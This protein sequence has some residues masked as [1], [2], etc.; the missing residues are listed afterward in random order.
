MSN[1]IS[2]PID[3][4][5][6]LFKGLVLHLGCTLRLCPTEN[7]ITLVSMKLGTLLCF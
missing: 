4:R 7:L 2:T 6:E 3:P 1:T 5:N